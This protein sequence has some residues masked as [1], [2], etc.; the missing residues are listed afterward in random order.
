MKILFVAAEATPFIKTGGLGDVIG[1]LPKAL[2]S[3]DL[4]VRVVL[5]KYGDV[6]REYA[7]QMVYKTNIY[8]PIANTKQ[9]CGITE[10]THQGVKFYFIDNEF[11]FNRPGLY[12]Y[13]DDAERFGFFCRA[14]LEILPHL[15]Y[16][17]D[18]IHCHDWHTALV[19]LYLH[20]YYQHLYPDIRTVF[21]IHNLKYQG[22]FPYLTLENILNIADSYF[23][24]DGL[25]YYGKINLLKGALNFADLITT[26]SESYAKEILLSEYGEGLH[27]LLYKRRKNVIGVLNGIDEQFNPAQD[28]YIY[29]NFSKTNLDNKA[30]NKAK[31]Q[32]ELSLP[33]DD[34]VPILAMITR[35]VDQKGIYLLEPILKEVLS[36]KVQLVILGTGSQNY[37]DYFR[38]VAASFP[39]QVSANI[40]FDHPLAQKIYAG[41]DL[42]LMPSLFEPCGLGQMIALRYG[43]IPIVRKTG[44]LNDTV[45]PYNITTGLGNGF[46]FVNNNPAELLETIK[47][48]VS[49]YQQPL[50]W[51]KL[52]NGAMSGDYSWHQSATKYRKIYRNLISF[53]TSG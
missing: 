22:I 12:G 26:V 7:K 5:P 41:S 13:G 40:K 44:G 52:V 9:Y 11:Y 31:L 15:D 4:D 28:K 29:A 48:A 25:E 24:M 30:I 43:S 1:S 46:V 50:V 32:A 2:K 35:L 21:T 33:V 23:T 38:W 3:K 53:K 18:I 39:S 17:P 45:Q 20:N 49:L 37:E 14:I 36:L 47:E 34:S 27:D 51:K 19:N 6:P 8:V 16:I 42:F 10:L